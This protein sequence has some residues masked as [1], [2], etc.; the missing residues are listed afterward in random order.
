MTA[1]ACTD[2]GA[3][4][5]GTVRHRRFAEH[6]HEFRHGLALLYVDVDRTGELLGGRLCSRRAGLIRLRRR[7]YLGDPAI[8]LGDAVR[9]LVGQRTGW[10]PDGSVFLLAQP[11]T[12][13]HCFNPISLYYCFDLAGRLQA[14][15]AEVT[16]TPW[17]ERHAY[18]ARADGERPV[19]QAELQKQLHV[20]PFMG[21]RQQYRLHCSA[22]GATL[23]VHIESTESSRRVFDATLS[24]RRRE[25]S[26]RSLRRT[27]A[28]YP[29]GTL[30]VLALI[31]GHALLLRLK[32]VH[33]HPRPHLTG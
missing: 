33:I 19:L 30:R 11:R 6:R 31:Y 24:L 29:A 7:D 1:G 5:A 21:M 4:Y 23:S 13:G 8:P 12:L 15:V 22:P 2:P 27:A 14:V 32:G 20:S 16:N 3:I 18:V 26:A 25:L 28:R 17:G 9:D 10:R